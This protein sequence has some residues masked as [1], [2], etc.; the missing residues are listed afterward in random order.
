MTTHNTRIIGASTVHAVTAECP[1]GDLRMLIEV[2]GVQ[3]RRQCAADKDD[4]ADLF[5]RAES[6]IASPW[7][8]S[9]WRLSRVGECA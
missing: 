5:N 2:R 7:G 9:E 1:D 4:L 3:W 6:L 8:W